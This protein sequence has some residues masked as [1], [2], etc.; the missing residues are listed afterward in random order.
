MW[1]LLKWPDGHRGSRQEAVQMSPAWA[2]DICLI[3]WIVASCHLFQIK[4]WVLLGSF[5]VAKFSIV[6]LEGR[7]EAH[8]SWQFRSEWK[9]PAESWWWACECKP[10]WRWNMHPDTLASASPSRVMPRSAPQPLCLTSFQTKPFSS[11]SRAKY[12]HKNTSSGQ[13]AESWHIWL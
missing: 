8:C 12:W 4:L 3:F 6:P 13:L 1:S 9:C 5:Q 2:G 11:V 10:D 7:R